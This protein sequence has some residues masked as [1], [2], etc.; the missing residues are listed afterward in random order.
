MFTLLR[1]VLLLGTLAAGAPNPHPRQWQPTTGR[2]IYFLTNDAENA[3]VAVPIAADGTLMGGTVTLTGGAGSNAINGMTN[4]TAAPDALLSQSSLAIAGN[5]LFA[6]NPGSNTLSMLSIS[7]SDPTHLTPIGHPAPI[8]GD[9]PTTV[10]VSAQHRLAC[11]GTT[12]ARA[13]I[14]CARFSPATGLDAGG[15]DALRPF[16]LGQTTPPAGPAN[17][18]SHAFF[19]A[20]GSGLYTTVKG[21]PAAGNNTGFFSVFAVERSDGNAAARLATE[22]T[23]SSPSGT[24]L[25]FGAADVPGTADVFVTDPSF[26]AAVLAVDG[27]SG[28]A[29]LVARGAIEGQKA[30]CWA[31]V[32]AATG[33]AFVA[34]AGVNRVVEMSVEDASV[35]SVLELGG[36]PLDDADP[37]L[38]DLKAAGGFVYALSPGNGTTGAAVA[39]LDVSGGRGKGRM[40]QH[41]EVGGLGAGKNAQGMVVLV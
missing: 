37:G 27:Q 14:S 5:H 31:T 24:A 15:G 34:D 16:D 19:S 2:A 40:V 29:R 35:V 3:V 8:P 33:T 6:V 38:T 11:V 20:D 39:V 30:T 1:D 41:F 12:G 36:G 21:D 9:F 17:T 7:P 10:A 25:L 18:V 32:S 13:G 4:A 28:E 22:D 23:R 26:G